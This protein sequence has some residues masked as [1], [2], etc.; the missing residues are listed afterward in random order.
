MNVRRLRSGGRSVPVLRR[1]L[2]RRKKKKRT[3]CAGAGRASFW[4]AVGV[5]QKAAVAVACGAAFP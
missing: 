5:A 1:R 2:G 4:R 3:G